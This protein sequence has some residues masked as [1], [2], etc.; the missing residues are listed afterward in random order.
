MAKKRKVKRSNVPKS[1]KVWREVQRRQPR[2]FANYAALLAWRERLDCIVVPRTFLEKA[3]GIERFGTKRKPWLREDLKEWFPYIYE[4]GIG[5]RRKRTHKTH[6]LSRVPLDGPSMPSMSE[7][8]SDEDRIKMYSDKRIHIANIVTLLGNKPPDEEEMMR[9]LI[10]L[11]SG[12]GSPK[13]AF[14]KRGR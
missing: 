4:L 13:N 11:A 8:M 2:I 7:T 1:Q 9:R 5:P 6:Y 3:C 10:S 12:L 14:R